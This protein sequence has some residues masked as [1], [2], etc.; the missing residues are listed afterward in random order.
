MFTLCSLSKGTSTS[1]EETSR[2]ADRLETRSVVI[3]S[4]KLNVSMMRMVD[5]WD[6]CDCGV[7]FSVSEVY[8]LSERGGVLYQRVSSQQNHYVHDARASPTQ[9]LSLY[10]LGVWRGGGV[11]GWRREP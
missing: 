4:K 8:K 9:L 2:C 11:A 5:I 6:E 10:L 1:G 7:R 3:S